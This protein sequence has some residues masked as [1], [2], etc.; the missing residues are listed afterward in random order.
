[1]DIENELKEGKQANNFL[2]KGF[3]YRQTFLQS[4]FAIPRRIGHIFYRN[5]RFIFQGSTLDSFRQGMAGIEI[6]SS[7]S[8]NTCEGKS[9]TCKVFQAGISHCLSR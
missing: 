4:I 8:I 1:M 9:N 6:K 3:N 7:L 5:Q 2:Q